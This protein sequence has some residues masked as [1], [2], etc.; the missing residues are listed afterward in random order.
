MTYSINLIK[1]LTSREDHLFKLNEAERLKNV[2][3]LL[4]FLFIFTMLTYVWTAWL[5][6][7]TDTISA[8]MTDLNRVEY[9]TRKAWF[10]IGR[11][12]FAL[13]L[14]LFILFISSFFFWLF[15]NVSYKKLFILQMN[16]LL[17]MLIERTT[18]IPL[19]IYAGID[20]YVS[21]FSF[22]VIASYFTTIDWVIYFFGAVSIFQL[23]IIW[24]QVKC[25]SW[26]SNT[27][28][29][30]IWVGVVFWHLLLWA[31]TSALTKFDLYLLYL[32][33]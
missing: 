2:W 4:F 16:V 1:L 29:G 33:R 5:G 3:N 30:W 11:V 24:Y 27:K 23:F 8:N 28:I 31:G 22:G 17:V 7:G 18:W 13:L 6:L 12:G 20:W 19:M 32:L 14:F 10:L 21:P 9:E 15:N 26:L 25:L